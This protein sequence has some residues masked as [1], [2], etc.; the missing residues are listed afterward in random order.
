MSSSSIPSISLNDYL[1]AYLTY[2]Q[3][4]ITTLETK[5]SDLEVKLAIFSD[6][7]EK[8]EDRRGPTPFS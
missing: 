3:A 8:L 6:L 1:S 4:P 7:K 2:L 5:K